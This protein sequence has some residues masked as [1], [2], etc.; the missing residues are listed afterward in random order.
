MNLLFISPNYPS[1]NAK[2]CLALKEQGVNVLGI[3]DAWDI[4]QELRE[5]LADYY[6]VSDIHDYDA[7]YR[8]TA[9]MISRHGRI[10]KAVSL[11]PY[12]YDVA[13]Q[14]CYDY[15]IE[16]AELSPAK[17]VSLSPAKEVTETVPFDEF[18]SLSAGRA[19]AKKYEY[20][21]FYRPNN[22]WQ[23]DVLLETS[24][25]ITKMAGNGEMLKYSA[26]RYISFEGL[27]ADGKISAV[28]GMVY[29]DLPEN[30]AESNGLFSFFTFNVSDEDYTM[31]EKLLKKYGIENS[32]FKLVFIES[33][34]QRLFLRAENV[35]SGSFAVNFMKL[36]GIDICDSWAKLMVGEKC[37]EHEIIDRSLVYVSRK[38]DRS[39]AHTH[40]EILR[41]Y[42][43]VLVNCGLSKES[44][45]S[46]AGDYYYYAEVQS[47]EQADEI[48]EYIQSDYR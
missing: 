19:F 45:S 36:C 8:G 32:L 25:G 5:A 15:R 3:G 42:A 6:V 33:G 1:C 35:I 34:G 29:P 22:G 16:H 2:F 30:A 38:F 43:D 46:A 40:P 48:I 37:G 17:F 24:K 26:E 14:I 41:K 18:K 13:E 20:P 10:D 7:V 11:I 27:A 39:Y 28:C 44:G 12:W 47:P 21:L 23:Q 31:C 9:Y 4:P